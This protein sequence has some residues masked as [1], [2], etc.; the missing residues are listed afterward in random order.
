MALFFPRYTPATTILFF[1]ICLQLPWIDRVILTKSHSPSASWG[2]LSC[3]IPA[4]WKYLHLPIFAW[5]KPDHWIKN[6]W[7]LSFSPLFPT[8]F[9][10]IRLRL[11]ILF[12]TILLK[13]WVSVASSKF[14]PTVISNSKLFWAQF[15][16]ISL[17]P[18]RWSNNP[19]D[20]VSNGV[21]LLFPRYSPDS[22]ILVFQICL[23]LPWI[24]MVILTESHS[25]FASWVRS[26]CV[27][28][29]L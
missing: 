15:Q 5:H 1:Q 3:V 23:Q 29:V 9:L 17:C 10:P 11:W 27:I 21:N 4:L 8:F 16:C 22:P 18:S 12:L 20:T 24:D 26:S 19:I 6:E 14:L 13:K 2:K 7:F 28:P 25:P